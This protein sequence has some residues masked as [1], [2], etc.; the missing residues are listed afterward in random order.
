[1]RGHRGRVVGSAVG[2]RGGSILSIGEDGSLKEWEYSS[3]NLQ[4]TLQIQKEPLISIAASHDGSL[5]AIAGET[6]QIRILDGA[7]WHELA[8][9]SG[10]TEWVT[11]V[12]ISRDNKYLVSGSLDSS[13]RLW[14]LSRLTPIMTLP[15][16]AERV[17]SVAISDDN[18]EVAAGYNSGVVMHWDIKRAA[19]DELVNDQSRTLRSHLSRVWC[20]LFTPSDRQL[21]SCGEGQAIRLWDLQS[22]EC[23]SSS[24]ASESQMCSVDAVDTDGN[25]AE[26]TLIATGGEDHQV[27]LWHWSSRGLERDEIL[28]GHEGRVWSVLTADEAKLYT[29]SED[30]TVREWTKHKDGWQNRVVLDTQRQIYNMDWVDQNRRLLAVSDESPKIT[31]V[32]GTT[33]NVV[34]T[35]LGHDGL[36]WSVSAANSGRNLATAS[37]DGTVGWWDVESATMLQRFVLNGVPMQGAAVS[38]DGG[39][40]FSAD[41]SGTVAIWDVNDGSLKHSFTAHDAPIW[42]MSL[43][44]SGEVL[45]TGASDGTI[46]L[47]TLPD[48]S[49]AKRLKGHENW[50]GRVRFHGD[51]ILLSVSTDGSAR[52]W[53][54]DTGDCLSILRPPR[55]YEGLD[56]RGC[57]GLSM[58]DIFVLNQLGALTD[59]PHRDA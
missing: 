42:G 17:W 51:Q 26:G 8:T 48:L 25:S 33:G 20:V 4:R 21:V 49:L 23:I 43:S 15:G 16:P 3:W 32:D 28:R 45:A 35:L 13:V 41:Y 52:V 53:N 12:A 5:I 31:I 6:N 37:F 27:R 46:A 22:G 9:L 24:E 11:T 19:S 50:L 7:T 57:S 29:A 1:M 40:I 38:K 59:H 2:Q 58:D 44:P 30:G 10:H 55:V 56:L 47:W 34:T 18:N 54:T 39:M 36:V 14:D